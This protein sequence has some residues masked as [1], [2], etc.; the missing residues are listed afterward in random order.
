[1]C[2]VNAMTNSTYTS[3][4]IATRLHALINSKPRSPTLAEITDL[5]EAVQCE[6]AEAQSWPVDKLGAEIRDA[7]A[8]IIALEAITPDGN[9][10]HDDA[11]SAAF[12]E[13][14]R[15]LEAA[16][17]KLP[18]RPRTLAHLVT[19]AELAWFWAD[20]TEGGTLTTLANVNDAGE[21]MDGEDE[22]SSAK[23]IAAVLQFAG[24]G[25]YKLEG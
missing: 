2:A 9:H 17:A 21:L 20:K 18:K 16:E 19:L 11:T 8:Q 6:Q 24:L 4:M 12:F 14:D 10:D 5:V 13:L 3:D 22:T 15:K 1:M 7:I 25:K 23:L